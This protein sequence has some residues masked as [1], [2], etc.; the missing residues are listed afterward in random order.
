LFYYSAACYCEVDTIANWTCGDAC[1][2]NTDVKTV[3]IAEDYLEGT[4]A[5]IAYNQAQNAIVV[6][7]RGSHNYANWMFDIDYF[8][9]PYKE[10]PPGAQVHTGFYDSYMSLQS[11]VIE[12]VSEMLAMYP[13]AAEIHVTGHSLGGGMATLGAVDIKSKL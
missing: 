1:T 13:N 5:L 9:E 11:Q 3:R 4:L 6:A 10:G 8:L 7:F 12:H 2:N